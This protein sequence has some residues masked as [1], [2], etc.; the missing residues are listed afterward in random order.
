MRANFQQTLSSCA[1]KATMLGYLHSTCTCI[2][3]PTQSI[4]WRW[5][6]HGLN[7]TIWTK[8]YEPNCW[9]L[10][11]FVVLRLTWHRCR[12]ASWTF[13]LNKI[14]KVKHGY[15]TLPKAKNLDARSIA[16]NTNP[17]CKLIQ[18]RIRDLY[19]GLEILLRSFL[20][21]HSEKSQI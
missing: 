7:R 12:V 16:L 2:M 11:S 20:G 9:P 17:T 21:L 8:L 6:K 1:I 15:C 14:E 18:F 13:S 5:L 10:D 19:L 4:E 3:K